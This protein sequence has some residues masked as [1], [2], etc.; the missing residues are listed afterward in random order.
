MR[1]ELKLE[2]TQSNIEGEL[3]NLIQDARKNMMA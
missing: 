1:L 2:F 3:V